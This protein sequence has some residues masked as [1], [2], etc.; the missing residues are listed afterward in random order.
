MRPALA[1][2]GGQRLR[3][4]HF[5]SAAARASLSARFHD[6]A[7]HSALARIKELLWLVHHDDVRM[8][9]QIQCGAGAALVRTSL[10]RRSPVIDAQPTDANTI[11]EK[12]VYLVSSD[13][14]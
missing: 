8:G 14:K 13:R 7:N 9:S 10:C 11:N 2:T 6:A 4:F 1:V 5:F 3:T 12:S